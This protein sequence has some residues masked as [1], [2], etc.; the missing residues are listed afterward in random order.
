MSASETARPDRRATGGPEPRPD[1]PPAYVPPAVLFVERLEAQ[2]NTCSPPPY[3]KAVITL[4]D[5][6]Q[7]TSS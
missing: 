4:T 6:T 1:A 2:A 7:V 5:C 3:A